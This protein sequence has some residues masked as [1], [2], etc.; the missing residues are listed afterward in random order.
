MNFHA[1][2]RPAM[3]RVGFAQPKQC[4]LSPAVTRDADWK[5]RVIDVRS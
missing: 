4:A 1:D 3:C 2:I 5:L